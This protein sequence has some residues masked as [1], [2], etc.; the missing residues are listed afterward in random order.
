MDLL[1]GWTPSFVHCHV[2]IIAAQRKY[3]RMFH[4]PWTDHVYCGWSPNWIFA[5]SKVLQKGPMY[6]GWR[7]NQLVLYREQNSEIR[8][9]FPKS[10]RKDLLLGQSGLNHRVGRSSTCYWF[11]MWRCKHY[12]NAGI[13]DNALK[14][15]FAKITILDYILSP[16]KVL[17]TQLLAWLLAFSF[18]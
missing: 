11:Y 18:F 1:T 14:F 6:F 4:W 3:K 17:V 8:W 16:S 13:G 10:E 5:G 9:R 15:C 12:T 2:Q 7:P